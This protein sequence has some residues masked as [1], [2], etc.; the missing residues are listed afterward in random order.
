MANFKRGDIVKVITPIISGTIE[1][2]IIDEEDMELYSIT[3]TDSEGN[4]HER[5]FKEEELELI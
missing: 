2:R 5:F 1:K 4:T 3:W